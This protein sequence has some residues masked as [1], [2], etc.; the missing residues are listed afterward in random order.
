MKQRSQ[1][2]SNDSSS[3]ASADE[4]MNPTL[5]M[6]RKVIR[7][8]AEALLQMSQRLDECFGEAVTLMRFAVEAKAKIVV[9]GV[10]KSGNVGHKIVAT[11]NSTGATAVMLHSQNALHGDLGVVSEGDVI[12]ALSYS[13]ETAEL[14]LVLPHLKRACSGLIAITGKSGSTLAEHADVVLDSSVE[15]EACPLDLAPTSSSTAMLV[16]G[17][18]LAMA[19]LDA[20]G[21]TEEDFARYHPGGSLGRALLTK[22]ADIMRSGEAM[23]QVAESA[24][25]ADALLAMTKARSGAC[26]VTCAD[27][28]LAGVFTHGDFVRAFQ[29][30]PMIGERDVADFMTRRPVT[31]LASALAVQAV[32]MIGSHRIDDVVVLGDAGQPVGLVDTQD[33]ARLRL[34]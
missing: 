32:N 10:G 33:L 22:V 17:D 31:V 7:M 28:T 8:E 15:R 12:L 23:A 25:V 19:L 2:K 14:L 34:V 29:R 5:E 18:A 3:F 11:L 16:M 21:F 4:P 20:R 30:E 27:G 24:T 1:R 13:G 9:V 26:V 6:G